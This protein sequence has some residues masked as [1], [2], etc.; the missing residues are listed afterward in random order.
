M[1]LL[2][3]TA[4]WAVAAPAAAQQEVGEVVV[5]AQRRETALQ[6]TPIAISALDGEA[7]QARGVADMRDIQQLVPGIHVGEFFGS[8]L[9]TVRAI[10]NDT[11]GVSADPGV[12]VHQDGVYLARRLYQSGAFFDVERIE[13]LRGPQGTLYGRGATG[14]A[15]N[16]MT[17]APTPEFE[18]YGRLTLGNYNL[19]VTEGAVSGPIFGSKVLGRVAFKTRDHE[20]Y[21]PNLFN[22]QRYDDADEADARVRLRFLP[23]ETLQIDLSADV[24]TVGG[25]G[26]ITP[27][28]RFDPAIAT[29][30]ELAGGVFAPGRAVNHDH[31]KSY[32][33]EYL[34]GSLNVTWDL[35]DLT[36]TSLSAARRMKSTLVYD[37]DGTQIA[38]AGFDPSIEKQDQL[39]QELTLSRTGGDLEWVAGL[40]W[41][42]EDA[43]GLLNIPFPLSPNSAAGL[44][45][46]VRTTAI[47]IY[48][49]ATWH[50][51]DKLDLTVGARWGRDSKRA[52]EAFYFGG[53]SGPLLLA[54]S[55][56]EDWTSFTPRAAVTYRLTS[57]VSAYAT[58]SRGFKP[59][60][61]NVWGFQGVAYEPETVTNYEI[62][63]KTAFADP[64]LT[65]NV[66]LFR[67]DYEDLQ[68]F[69]IQEFLPLITN[70]AE[71][72]IDG[73]E[74]EVTFATRGGLS[75]NGAVTWL[76]ANF[77]RYQ[78]PDPARGGQ[79]FD[80]AG[81]RLTAT[82]KWAVNLGAE[83]ALGLR[84]GQLLFGVDYSYKSRI[85]FRAFN[86]L[87]SA[88]K[89]YGLWNGRVAW[90]PDGA[91]WE[92]SIW[93]RNATDELV[94]GRINVGG[95]VLGSPVETQYLPP[96]TYGVTLGMSF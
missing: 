69:Q 49:D 58:V 63:L 55:L 90:R 47:A 34:G 78:A 74:A 21:T 15:V 40:F 70:A 44:I 75:L 16:I 12:A 87:S 82:P 54:D 92:A 46:G 95:A 28:R 31:P 11:S 50:A 45:D 77:D 5:T 22:G 41:F 57:D 1:A 72:T 2:L 29:P 26:G 9:V 91:G 61:F 80:L 93:V 89:A 23:T 37:I 38:G 94:A 66:S 43:D 4:A 8:T 76:D 18:G 10:G 86:D 36:L 59:G 65:A 56:K 17:R 6:D 32:D 96:R 39:S 62:G 3:T 33:A 79:V 73:A 24:R 35:G 27:D 42:D 67:M 84:G 14:G 25:Y 30:Q 48:G 13:V 83:Y 88:Q 20:G 85:Y 60:G 53:V 71:A 81:N 19:V 52:D 64:R 7:L 68:V 51:G